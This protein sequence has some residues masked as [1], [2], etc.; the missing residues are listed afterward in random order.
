MI[1]NRFQELCVFLKKQKSSLKFQ[2]DQF[3]A[4]IENMTVESGGH[5]ETVNGVHLCNFRYQGVVYIERLPEA[6][7]P[8][9]AIYI[10]S[11]LDNNDDLR[12][13]YKLKSPLIDVVSLGSKLIDAMATIDFVDEVY[14]V[15]ANVTPP[16]DGSPAI[17]GEN[18]V[19]MF[20]AIYEVGEYALSIA[21]IGDVNGGSTDV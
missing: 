4:E 5:N 11:W 18:Q 8:M 20:G 3:D 14:L 19:E 15:K 21:E 13:K 2:D 16:D 6:S 7:F 17:P 9:L 10:K 12:S 1:R